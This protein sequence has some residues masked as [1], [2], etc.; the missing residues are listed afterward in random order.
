MYTYFF[1]VYTGNSPGIL[2]FEIVNETTNYRSQAGGDRT[3]QISWE[4]KKSSGG[5]THSS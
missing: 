3:Y 1:A 5:H 2:S 4:K